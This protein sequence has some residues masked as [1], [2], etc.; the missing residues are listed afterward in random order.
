[1]CVDAPTPKPI[2]ALFRSRWHQG[3]AKGKLRT[4]PLY[5][6]VYQHLAGSALPLLDLG[7]GI[8]LLALYLRARGHGPPVHGTDYDAKKIAAANEAARRSG[9]AGLSFVHGDAR[10]G[11]PDHRG[12]I[13]ILDI[14]QFFTGDE[15]RALL[16]AAAERLAPG[17]KLII[18]TGIKD[19]GWRF[20][21]TVLGDLIAKATFWMK[22]APT[23]YPTARSLRETLEGAGLEVTLTPLWGKTPFNN[24]LLVARRDPL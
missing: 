10:Q 20:K 21:V 22:S 7:C 18:R 23:H 19:R 5:G 12:D 4:D 11:L 16:T 3:Y 8:G 24:H 6:A 2:A 14:L 15:Q 1:M 17:G 9:H 13:T